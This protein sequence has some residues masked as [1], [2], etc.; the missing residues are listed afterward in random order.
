MGYLREGEIL[1]KLIDSLRIA[2]QAAD[3]IAVRPKKGRTYRELRDALAEA[4][5]ACRQMGHWR[6]QHVWL[7]LGSTMHSAHEF[8][9]EWLRGVP[10][11]EQTPE[12][13]WVKR[14][15]PLKVGEK[16]PR[17]VRLAEQLRFCRAEAQKMADKATGVIGAVLPVPV[18]NGR[19][20]GAP[21]RVVLPPGMMKTKGGLI[22]PQG[23]AS[24]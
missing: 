24:Q 2:A 17:F 11:E 22:V 18:H 6:G 19:R 23:M 14:H 16:H 21:V 1:D 4:E 12:G 7:N 20:V 15:R 3:D 9:G 10:Y 5:G 13:G 8:A